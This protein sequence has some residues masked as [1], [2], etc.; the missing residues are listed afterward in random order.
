MPRVLATLPPS[1]PGRRAAAGSVWAWGGGLA[2]W[3]LGLTLVQHAPG[4]PSWAA[5]T[6][7]GSALFLLGAARGRSTVTLGLA[8]VLAAGLLAG[9]WAIW[10]ADWRLAQ[11]LDR[12]WEGQEL[13]LEGEVAGLP[14]AI[15]GFG[16]QSGWRLPVRGDGVARD[17][18]T[19]Q[20][21]PVP[22]GLS[23]HWFPGRGRDLAPRAGERWRWSVRLK[24]V[25]TPQNPN[26]PDAELWLLERDIRAQ[27]G[28]LGGV[29]LR[30]AP[31]HSLPAAREALRDA[32]ARHVADPRH[33]AVIGGLVLGDQASLLVLGI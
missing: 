4:W 20:A 19:G 12:A 8:W 33:R 26:V 30:A 2:A 22:P 27:G 31:W 16:G 32:I 7:A 25:H 10:R 13:V 6:A 28:V 5:P 17:T 9:A 23:L 14:T 18:L 1:N 21:V 3:M 29:R 11:A 15:D 24:R